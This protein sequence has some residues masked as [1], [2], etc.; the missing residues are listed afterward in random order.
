MNNY[1]YICIACRL[2]AS[3]ALGPRPPNLE[4][5]LK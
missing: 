5:Q 2:Q 1:N 4:R 3:P